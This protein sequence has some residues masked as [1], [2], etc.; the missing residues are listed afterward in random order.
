MKFS[1]IACV[2]LLSA[3]ISTVALANSAELQNLQDV[4]K[5]EATRTAAYGE[6]MKA[7]NDLKTIGYDK[8]KAWSGDKGNTDTDINTKIYK[9]LE[10]IKNKKN[11]IKGNGEDLDIVIKDQDNSKL[12]ISQ[13]GEIKILIKGNQ[14]TAIHGNGGDNNELTLSLDD[15]KDGRG[16]HDKIAQIFADNN[17]DVWEAFISDFKK[18]HN[19]LK[20]KRDATINEKAVE[21]AKATDDVA[22]PIEKYEAFIENKSTIENAIKADI[23]AKEKAVTEAQKT[24]NDAIK[25][26]DNKKLTLLSKDNAGITK[27]ENTIKNELT[28]QLTEA[29]GKGSTSEDIAEKANA[30]KVAIRTG[31]KLQTKTNGGGRELT[32]KDIDAIAAGGAGLTIGDFDNGGAQNFT[33]GDNIKK[34]LDALIG[35]AQLNSETGAFKTIKAAEEE[36]KKVTDEITKVGTAQKN[37]K[38]SNKLM[39]D[40]DKTIATITSSKE[41]AEAKFMALDVAIQQKK[42]PEEIKTAQQE[43]KNAANARATGVTKVANLEE[44]QGEVLGSFTDTVL[45]NDTVKSIVTTYDAKELADTAKALNTS[46]EQ[47]Q[48]S[49]NKGTSTDIIMFNTGLATN[50]RLAKLSN[51]FNADLALAQAINELEGETF[52]DA[53]DSLSSVIKEYTNRFNHDNNLWG[54]IFGGKGKIK[55]SANPSIWGVT[56]GYDKAFDNTIVGGFINYAKV[57]SKDSQV[58][59][60]SDNYSFGVYS[61]S[62]FDQSE[63]DAKIGY[64][65][66]RNELSRHAMDSKIGTSTGKYDSKFFDVDVEYGYVFGLGNAMFIKPIAGLSYTHIKHDGFTEDGNVPAIFGNTNLKTLKAKLGSEFRVY[67]DNASYFYITPGVERELSKSTNDLSVKFVGSSKDV[68]FDADKKK[69][70]YITLKTGAEFK[71]TNNL[72]TNINFGAKAKAKEQY[73]NGTLG[74]SYKF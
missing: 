33:G 51:P 30:L 49:Q 40:T 47:S 12:T 38:E 66:G 69:N 39:T 32:E 7:V 18:K 29:K 46:I 34:V 14:N 11:D 20:A 35:D 63:I 3:S 15:F 37:L 67:T 50:T 4:Q 10:V 72:S 24:L 74:V 31:V 53:G 59:S 2:A 6:I 26:V 25:A 42:Q 54:N 64:G 41:I 13:N 70:T 55:D 48:R 44:K 16:N 61:R 22:T 23:A 8:L 60:E 9:A 56:L 21:L 36:I 45:A 5:D 73:Y 57:Q 1:K 62:Y 27:Q 28:K 17:Q 43:L 58:R 65:F 68:V 19:E 52:A 71:I